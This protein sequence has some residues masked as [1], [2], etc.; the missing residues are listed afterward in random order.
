MS[1]EPFGDIPLFREIQKLLSSSE[2]PLNLEIARQVGAAI[3][4]QAPSPPASTR[5]LAQSFESDVAEAAVLIAGYT[6]LTP[7]EPMRTSMLVRAEWVPASLESWRWLLERLAGRLSA[8]GADAGA[9]E[10]DS[11]PDPMQAMMGQVAPLLLGLQAGT[12]VGHLATESLGR[13]DPPI[14]REDDGRLFFVPEN[15]ASLATEYDFDLDTFTRWLALHDAARHLVM[16]SVPWAGRYVRSLFAEVVDAIEIDVNDLEAR[17]SELQAGGMEVLE[18]GLE[19]ATIM[20]IAQTERHA[21]AL[22]RLR[23]FAAVLEGYAHHA[24]EQVAERT[25]ADIGRINEGMTRR[26]A[27]PT[28]ARTMLAELLGVSFD[29]DLEAAG[30]TFCAAVVQ[31]KGMSVLNR[32]WDAPDNVPTLEEVKDPFTWM[33]RVT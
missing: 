12:L 20:P 26:N 24:F 21:R 22:D 16:T 15:V 4:A 32:I 31:L 33:E 8:A 25:L 18:G 30:A 17:L 9:D 29:R 2:G 13:Y 28:E 10:R 19:P 27:A 6:R 7:D 14:P 1:Q 23:A 11:Q 3:V 5:T